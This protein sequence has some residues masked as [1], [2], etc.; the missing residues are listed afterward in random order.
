MPVELLVR[1]LDLAPTSIDEGARTVR[2]IWSTGVAVQRRDF[3]GPFL[4]VL[5]LDP[6]HVRLDQLRGASVLDTHSQFRLSDV[7]GVVAEAG[8]S[9]GEGWAV[10]KFSSRA[11]VAPIW[12]D[13]CDG[14]IRHVSVGYSVEGWEE[15][16]GPNGVRAKTATAWTPREISFVPLPADAGASVRSFPEMPE[17][18]H[19]DGSEAPAT[20]A[21]VNAEIRSIASVAGLG[22][23][24]A[25]GLIDRGA[26]LDAARAA[27]FA[28][29][30]ANGGAIIRTEARVTGGADVDNPEV[31]AGWMADALYTR[32][33]PTHQPNEAARQY[34]GLTIPEMGREILRLRGISTTGLSA[35][36]VISRALG[37]MH[38]TS[39]FAMILGDTVGRTLRQAYG[40]VP[41]GVRRLARQ[42]TARD[43]RAKHSV[44]LSEAPTLEKV[45]EHGEFKAGTMAE[46]SESYALDTFGRII[47]IS[48][49]ALVN[50]DLGAFT[51][52]SRRFGIAA[53]DFEAQ[54]LVNLLTKDAG[55]GP[56]M[57]DD[58]ALFHASHA[59]LAGSG[60]ALSEDTLSAARL[61][62]RMQKGLSGTPI[63]VTPKYLL[64]PAALETKA[65]K[66]LAAI[67]ATT[68]GDVNPH[69]G[70]LELVVDSRLDAVSATRWYV[71]GDPATIDG[72][73][74]AYLEGAPGPQID[75]RAGFEVD[76]VQVRVRLDFG[77]GFVDWRGWYANA[78]A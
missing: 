11:D 72:L 60:A 54:F 40:S 34:V 28:T 73:E 15:T 10:V 24:F 65:E 53:A 50:D 47:G 16:T 13:V 75:S 66:V 56:I 51:D 4:E 2:V 58:A 55:A 77:A 64:V 19:T 12:Q 14:I 44:Q 9:N 74:Y 37:G 26:S 17:T 61:A 35:D 42:T 70:K 6:A 43:F 76:G 59:N 23:E 36:A 30:Q 39:D 57:S 22:A 27:A 63:D 67:T 68:T 71:A 45:N 32:V 49:Q 5:S 41:S 46:A 3:E 25:N 21:A 7:L 48:R 69:A 38:T 33:N 29:L 1:R 78:G 20:R 31:R 8:V 62:L 52:L 18:V